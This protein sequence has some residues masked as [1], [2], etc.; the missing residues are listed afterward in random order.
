MWGH[1]QSPENPPSL[2]RSS[3]PEN[4]TAKRQVTGLLHSHFQS[5][6]GPKQSLLMLYNN[7]SL[8]FTVIMIYCSMHSASII[9][10][11]THFGG[12]WISPQ[13][14]GVSFQTQKYLELAIF[15]FFF[16]PARL[17]AVTL[18]EHSYFRNFTHSTLTE[19]SK[20][21]IGSQQEGTRVCNAR[22]DCE[23]RHK[24]QATRQS[25]V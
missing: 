24:A 12:R 16:L 15:H 2:S 14:T 17:E 3:W 11:L 19:T 6:P 20:K 7:I 18:K 23:Y 21:D 8:L 9:L 4:P 25:A 1:L 22:T 5:E 13:P 10:I